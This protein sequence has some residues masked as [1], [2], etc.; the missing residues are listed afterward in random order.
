[1]NYSYNNLCKSHNLK[2]YVFYV[3][4][5]ICIIFKNRPG[6]IIFENA[7]LDRQQSNKSWD[8]LPEM[9]GY[10][11]TFQKEK[12]ILIGRGHEMLVMFLS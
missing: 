5:S 12:W 6:K 10:E 1:M 4:L 11:S 8:Q 7:Y 3:H 9:L 2:E